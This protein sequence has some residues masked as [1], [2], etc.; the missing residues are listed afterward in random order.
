M[1]ILRL[2]RGGDVRAQGGVGS[3]LSPIRLSRV[4]GGGGGEQSIGP[5]PSMAGLPL[6]PPSSS[7]CVRP[8]LVGEPPSRCR[9]VA[10]PSVRLS[11]RSSVRPPAARP[12]DRPPTRSPARPPARRPAS[13]PSSVPDLMARHII[14]S[15]N[16]NAPSIPSEMKFCSCERSVNLSSSNEPL[17]K[18]H[19]CL[20]VVL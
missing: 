9:L 1:L 17:R 4:G 2:R 6:T 16:D 14:R 3:G 11:V 8:L 10:R 13:A 19:G 7:P 5:F 12:L 20:I 18:Q 15:R